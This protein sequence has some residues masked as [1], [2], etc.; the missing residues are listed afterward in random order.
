MEEMGCPSEHRNEMSEPSLRPNEMSELPAAREWNGMLLV[1]S[2]GDAA[3]N[4]PLGRKWDAP[5]SLGMKCRSPSLRPN[6]M[7][8]LLTAPEW[9]GLLLI[10]SDAIARTDHP[11]WRKWDAPQSIG[12]KCQNPSLRSND[13]SELLTAPEWSVSSSSLWREMS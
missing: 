5:Q 11:L 7:S 8:E 12:M 4:H 2:E 3:T 9:N 10:A 13:M 1:T 6:E